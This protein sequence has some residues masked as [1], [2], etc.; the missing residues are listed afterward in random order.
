MNVAIIVFS[1]SG[2]S[3]K[4]AEMIK[5][6]CEEKDDNVDLLN[7]T[8][9]PELLYEGNLRENLEKKLEPWDLIFIGGP[10]YAGHMERSI[11]NIIKAL[12]SPSPDYSGLA[13]PFTTYGGAHSFIALEETGRLLKKKDYKSL[14]GIKV[15]AKH[16]L[17]DTLSHTIYPDKPGRE[18]EEL[19]RDGV[20]RAR[21]IALSGREAA[22]DAGRAFRYAPI[23]FRI[24][25]K[26][27]TQ[28]KMHGKFKQ[29][30]I[31]EDKC[32]KCKKCISACPV[33]MFSFDGERVVMNPEGS[34]CILCAECF[35]NC[36][37]EAIDHPY[38]EKARQRL[39][40]GNPHMEE[41]VSA[42]YQ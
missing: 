20:D 1:P 9:K 35:H 37:A 27:F 31:I 15:A 40:D 13:V 33:N 10:I 7:I 22:V 2:H 14:L 17:T 28:E 36:P 19:I 18:E 32:I 26:F 11:L 25:M 29:V 12:P 39:N 3:L 24:M 38:I 8:G 4:A 6:R 23:K 41:P 5:R 16:T 34:R 30:R 21:E 42:I